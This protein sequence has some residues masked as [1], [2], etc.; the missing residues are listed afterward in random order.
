MPWFAGV[1]RSEIN[2][3]PT[4][5]EKRCV[6]CGMCLNCGK[7]VFEWKDD[8]SVVARRDNC[9]VGC[10]SCATLCQGKCITFPPIEDL[11][12][13]YKEHQIWTHVKEAMVEE[14]KITAEPRASRR[15]K[16][17]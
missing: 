2:W 17:E 10:T 6:G 11:R 8:K 4:I 16:K 12:R 1:P 9:S 14:G 5:D 13:F 3:G 15:D 7:K